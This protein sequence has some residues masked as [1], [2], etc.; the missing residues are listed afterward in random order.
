MSS[1]NNNRM[2]AE[3]STKQFRLNLDGQWVAPSSDEYFSCVDP[4]T[5]QEWGKVPVADSINVHAAVMAVGRNFASGD[6]PAYTAAQQC[7]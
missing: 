6:W 4:F 5:E 7:Q 3:V 2:P 1:G